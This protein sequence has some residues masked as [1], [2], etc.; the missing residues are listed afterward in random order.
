MCFSGGEKN[1]VCSYA[2]IGEDCPG[3]KAGQGGDCVGKDTDE[4]QV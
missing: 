4:C 2:S 3:L 1:R